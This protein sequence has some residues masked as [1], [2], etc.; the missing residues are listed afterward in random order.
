[1]RI[2]WKSSSP[3]ACSAH[4]S[5]ALGQFLTFGAL[6]GSLL[7]SVPARAHGDLTQDQVE[8]QLVTEIRV[9]DDSGRPVAGNAPALPLEIGKPFDFSAE[10]ESL[11]ALYRTG[12]FADIRVVAAPV[13]A[14]APR[15]FH[16]PA[17]LLQQCSRVEGLKEPPSEAAAL[18]AMRL[19]FGEPFRESTLREAIGRLKDTLRN[20]GLYEADV[21][22]TLTP[23]ED[24]RQMDVLVTR[25]PGPRA[26]VGNST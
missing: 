20:K 1:M 19:S 9:L 2:P 18:A 25:T 5:R 26:V 14:R 15:G 16:R 3:R 8:G 22:W 10:R 13:G 4:L 6:A 21:K 12:D 24:T 23:H 11:R 17:Q 7:A